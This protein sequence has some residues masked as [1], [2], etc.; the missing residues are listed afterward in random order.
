M[1]RELL[2]YFEQKKISCVVKEI[3]TASFTTYNIY[4]DQINDFK[5]FNS[6]MQKELV[7]ILKTNVTINTN[8]KIENCIIETIPD[9]FTKNIKLIQYIILYIVNQHIITLHII[10]KHLKNEE[11]YHFF[12]KIFVYIRKKL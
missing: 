1:K 11:K 12:M 8:D 3:D 7:Y 10:H 4:L 9:I 5:K 2:K 6:S